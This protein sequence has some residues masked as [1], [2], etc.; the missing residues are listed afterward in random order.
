M[1]VKTWCE[2]HG[3]GMFLLSLML[4]LVVLWVCGCGVESKSSDEPPPPPPP[5]A[6]KDF[7]EIKPVIDR[8][9]T[10]CHNGAVHPLK[11]DTAAKFK[12]SKS[13]A[14]ISNGTMPPAGNVLS[15]EDK[16]K[17]LAYLGTK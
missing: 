13:K 4:L 9:C 12:G 6:D 2:H 14:R 15:A 10:K 3:V 7:D 1:S 8:N 5:A 17:L 11:F 16:Q